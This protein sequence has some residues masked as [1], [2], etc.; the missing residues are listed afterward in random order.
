M[1]EPTTVLIAAAVAALVGFGWLA[2]AMET[3]WEQVHGAAPLTPGVVRALRLAGALGLA[4][5]L[6][7]CLR[8]D[9]P[10]MAALV[11]LMLMADAAAMVAMTLSTRP[12]LLR[13]I[14]PVGRATR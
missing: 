9:H 6:G 8:A 4:L 2:L 7:L 3:H 10:S 12:A 13:W 11:W 14:W 1:A 5:S